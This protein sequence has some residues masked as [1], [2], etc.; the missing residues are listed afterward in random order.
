LAKVVHAPDLRFEVMF[1]VVIVGG[2]A[3]GL[4]AALRA[5]AAG[6]EVLVVERD[7]L[8]RGSTALSAGLIPAPDTR[9]QRAAGIEDSAEA[10][11]ADI[12]KKAEGEPDPVAVDVLAR[13]IGPAI[14]WLAD[15]HGLPFSVIDNFTY[16]GHSARRMH[17]LPSRSGSEL[18]DAL[19]RA[20]ENAGVLMLTDAVADT[21]FTASDWRVSG[22]ALTRPDGSSE[23]IGCNALVLACNGYGGNPDLV[24]RHV[25]DMA[26]ALYFGHTGNRGDAVL[27]GEALGARTRHLSG[28]QGHGSVAEPHGILITWATV[29]E[30]GF[31]INRAGERF[32][33]EATGYSEAAAQV[34]AQP[35]GKVWQVFD[36]RIANIARQFED[37]R[38]AERQGAIITASDW[39]TLAA[40]MQVDAGV[41]A[42]TAARVTTFKQSGTTDTFGRGWTGIPD[43][44]APLHA[45]RVQ[46]ALFHTQ[47]GL[48]VD[49][50]ARVVR[51]GG[52]AFHNLFAAGGAACGV[53]GSKASGYL[54]GNG[55]LT[56]IGYGSIAGLAAGALTN[57][58]KSGE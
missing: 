48:V 18:M 45:V 5:R 39:S 17:G 15:A 41:L 9:F 44:I 42:E 46:G 58:E 54:S 33:N 7:P 22:I 3:A 12:L 31:Q 29:T 23:T 56:A 20:A 8:P 47:G 32:A 6:R 11:A 57:R 36:A 30:G 4:V 26:G 19:H 14:E 40:R 53:S 10:F 35:G 21:L 1:D 34:I 13:S 25:P 49:T 27:W 16:P 55:L 37:F 50:D 28:Y 38:E 24:A 2:G 52:T 51:Q 43:L